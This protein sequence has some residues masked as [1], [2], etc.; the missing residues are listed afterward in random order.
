MSMVKIKDMLRRAGL[1]TG[2]TPVTVIPSGDGGNV[3]IEPITFPAGFAWPHDKFPIQLFR[4]GRNVSSS[5]VPQLQ[6]NPACYTGPCYH[7]DGLYGLDTNTGLGSYVG[8]Y[9]QAFKT[10]K[11]AQDTLNAGGVP[12]RIKVKIRKGV[13][14]NR[15]A[16]AAPWPIPTVPTLA[17]GDGPGR[18]KVRMSDSL[19]WTLQSG[20]MYWAT[21]A[22]VSR[23]F[24]T[25][26]EDD[27]FGNYVELKKVAD[28]TVV[29]TTPGSWAQGAGAN[30]GKVYVNRLDGA[31]VTDSNTAVML[32]TNVLKLDD[33]TPSGCGFFNFEFEGGYPVDVVGTSAAAA[34]KRFVFKNCGA[35]YSHL[36]FNNWRLRDCPGLISLIEC[37]GFYGGADSFNVHWSLGGQSKLYVYYYKCRSRYNGLLGNLSNNSETGHETCVVLSVM[38]DLG[39]SFGG[40]VAYINDSQLFIVEPTVLDSRGDVVFGGGFDP[41]TIQALDNAQVWLDGGIVGCKVYALRARQNAVIR[42]RGTRIVG[43][44]LSAAEN[45]RIEMY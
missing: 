40:E 18:A 19:A 43:G 9:S 36:A 10:I 2:A 14:F 37:D 31:A 35:R 41:V 34:D 21:R 5:L 20:T 39:S 1:K 24:D 27:E 28:E 22:N 6:V 4:T 44:S 7:V 29:A 26:N 12:G 13:V 17:E 23:V 30:S 15:V 16:G 8:D 25:L 38:P 45:G 42:Y 33:T 11:K 32:V 3:L